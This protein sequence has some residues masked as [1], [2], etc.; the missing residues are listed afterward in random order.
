[1]HYA[2]GILD[3]ATCGTCEGVNHAVV[4]VGKS[5]FIKFEKSLIVHLNFKGFGTENGKKYWIIR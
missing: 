5:C 1:M 2:S 3:D 4:I